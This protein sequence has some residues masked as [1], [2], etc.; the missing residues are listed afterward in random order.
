MPGLGKVSLSLGEL[1]NPVTIGGTLAEPS[2][3]VNPKKTAV[4]FG[5]VIG[6]LALGPGALAVVFGDVSKEDVNPCLEAIKAAEAPAGD[7]APAEKKKVK[8][9]R[10]WR[11]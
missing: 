6:G 11:K 2:I 7:G 4:T 1:T 8:K 10:W 3:T 9:T 5:K